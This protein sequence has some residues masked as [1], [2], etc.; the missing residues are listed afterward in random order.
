MMPPTSFKRTVIY[1]YIRQNI[2]L[3]FF[4]NF[5]FGLHTKCSLFYKKKDRLTKVKKS[6]FN[7]NFLL[8]VS[9]KS[10]RLLKSTHL[11]LSKEDEHFSTAT[12]TIIDPSGQERNL[13]AAIL[14]AVV[15]VGCHGNRVVEM[16][17][18]HKKTHSHSHLSS[19][20]LLLLFF[21]DLE[22][23][24]SA[25]SNINNA[26]ATNRPQLQNFKL[27]DFYHNSLSVV[28]LAATNKQRQ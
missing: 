7:F 20:F 21:F 9:S 22:Y 19:S 3:L 2:S 5:D 26:L 18:Q 15:V 24:Y 28:C 4:N 27:F 6:V 23:I 17:T 25:S 13:P 8:L 16:T 11:H 10:S 1:I 12:T 14:V